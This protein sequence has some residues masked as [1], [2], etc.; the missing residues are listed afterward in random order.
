MHRSEWMLARNERWIHP[1]RD[2]LDPVVIN[3]SFRYRKQLNHIPSFASSLN[4]TGSD[5]S[6]SFTVNRITGNIRVKC[7]ARENSCLLSRIVA[8]N[9]ESWVSL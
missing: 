9:I 4:L 6:D 3:E 1:G 2:T 5:L 8:L 7:E